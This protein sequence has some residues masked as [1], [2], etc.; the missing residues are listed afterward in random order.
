MTKKLNQILDDQN[1][2]YVNR[3]KNSYRKHNLATKVM[4]GGN[5]RTTQWMEPYPFFAENAEGMYINDIDGNHYLDFMLNATTLILGHAHPDIVKTLTQ[6]IQDGT[7]YSV[8]TDGQSKLADILVERVPSFEKVRFTNSGTEAT[9]MAIMAARS[10]TKKTKIAKFEG[11][12]HGTHDHVSVSVYPKKEDL[13]TETHPG[14]PEYSYQPKSIL[15]DVIVLP[16]ND[17]EKSKELIHKFKDDLSCIIMEPIISNF[18]YLPLDLEFIKFIREI[19]EE[20]GIVLIFDEIQSFRVS[21]GGAQESFGVTPDMTT[22][23]KIIGG[24]LPVGAF[25]GKDE[26]MELFDPTSSNYDIAHAG[27]FNGNPLTMEAGVTVMENLTSNNFEKMNHLGDSLRSKLSSVFNEINLDVQVTGY[28]SLFGINFNK[29]KI[30]DYRSFLNNNSDMTKILF[31]Y[32]RNKGILLQLKNA[33][34]LNILMTEK[35]IDYLVDSTREISSEMK[36]TLDE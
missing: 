26:I 35:E 5:T 30:K 8:P 16:Y 29:N 14:V 33:G 25:G 11:G 17:I 4:P 20:L 2:Q 32:L 12:Y 10:F 24:G 1:I 18:G 27:T 23:G 34:A 9:M 7:V 3:T 22:L 28:G 15:E 19:T 31:S 21:S 13:N 36:D 6:Q